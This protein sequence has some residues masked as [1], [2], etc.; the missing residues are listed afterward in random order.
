MKIKIGKVSRLGYGLS[1]VALTIAIGASMVVPGLSKQAD[2]AQVTTRSIKMS[3]AAPSATG[4]SYEL[5]FTP[6]T[7]QA[8]TGGLIVDFCGDTPLIGASCAFAA[9]TVPNVAS[10]AAS[11][12]TLATVGS[13]TPVHTLKVTGLSF[14][15]S[16]PFTIT[17]TGMANP[18]T[19]TSFYARILTYSSSA[20]A[21]GYVPANTTGGATTTGTY[22]DYGGAALSTATNVTVTARVME[23]L[24]FCASS[25]SLASTDCAT[26]AGANPPAIDLGT[27]SPTPTLS[28]NNVD[29]NSI[30]TQI[31]TNAQTGAVVRLKALNSCANGGLSADGGTTCAIP[32]V[33]SSATAI[34]AGTAAFGL[35]VAAGTLSSGGTG[36]S[37]ATTPYNHASNY[38]MDGTS[39]T[40]TYGDDLFSTGSSFASPAPC[41][42]VNNQFT[43]AATPSLTTP[44]GIYTANE[45]LIATGTF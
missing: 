3:S 36:A 27:G 1:A 39:V 34:V 17:F 23:T 24:T 13:G 42:L 32:G 44:A 18:T 15:A 30:Y 43:F 12:G 16:T 5:T 37:T 25:Q 40:S 38:G 7:T 20:N 10:A 41:S 9:G 31:S 33:G 26:N 21:N 8:T 4:V 35:R 11:T 22:L 29:T 2:A 19:A 28:P 14:T 45:S 6:A